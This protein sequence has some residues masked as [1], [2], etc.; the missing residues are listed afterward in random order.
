MNILLIDD[1]PKIRNGLT[2]LLS[3]HEGW[4]VAGAFADAASALK[5]LY[6]SDC[7]VI[8]S[9]IKMP[10]MSGLDMIR[11]I[12]EKDRGI[13]ILI[14]S[15]YGTFSFAQRAIELGVRK[16]LTKP[17]NP[18]EL[19]QALEEIERERRAEAESLR[20]R[21]QVP[22]SNLLVL[23]AIE[24]LESHYAGKIGLREVA[25][26]LYISPNYLSELFKKQTGQTFSDYLLTVRM[27]KARG[28]LENVE[29]RVSDIAAMTG[30]SDGRY[31][32]STFKKYYGMTPL[33]YRNRAQPE[34]R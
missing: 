15:G 30:F 27:E 29:Y 1:E 21:E 7:D 28:F 14:L 19:T 9:D 26:V 6:E 16:Y 22:V 20:S 3:A 13:P 10:G 11:E 31:F 32:S 12:R 23:R 5:F 24:Y 18:E 8:I 2:H 17:T 34:R 33:E 4:S 25:G